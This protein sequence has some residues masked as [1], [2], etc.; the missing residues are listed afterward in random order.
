MQSAVLYFRRV[1][2]KRWYQRGSVHGRAVMMTWMRGALLL[3]VLLGCSPATAQVEPAVGSLQS[4]TLAT[5]DPADLREAHVTRAVDG[6]SLDAH[7]S[8][9]RTLVGYLGAETPFPSQPCGQEALARNRELATT[10]V[11]LEADPAYQFDQHGRRLFY[12]YTSDGVSIDEALVRDGL[13]R[14]V[15]TDGRYGAYLAQL[16]ADAEAAGRGCLWSSSPAP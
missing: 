16:Q 11:T 4:P 7:I 12:T 14:A 3:L 1:P 5:A 15:R 8:G 10:V 6:A 9:N 2:T 13:A